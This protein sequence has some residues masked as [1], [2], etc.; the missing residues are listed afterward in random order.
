MDEPTT[1]PMTS[2]RREKFE[3]DI[4]QVQVKTGTAAGEQRLIMAGIA[5]M[6][7]GAVV[8]LFATLSSGGQS[9]TRDILT[10]VIMG[11]FGLSLVIAGAAVFLRYSLGRFMRFWLLRMIYEQQS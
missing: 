5:L 6:A 1:T 9:D 7:I 4:A 3:A 8:A 2:E 10:L 11:T